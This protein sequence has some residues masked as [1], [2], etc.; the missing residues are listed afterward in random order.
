MITEVFAGIP[1]DD[2]ETATAWYRIFVNREPD[3]VPKDGEVV[4]RLA[5]NGWI[6]VVADEARAGSTI[7]TLLVDDLAEQVGSLAA[8]G[9]APASVETTPG[10]FRKAIFPDPA[11][12]TITLAQPG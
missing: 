6:Y 4:W 2:F 9:I 1:V 3:M 7:V 8:R 10:L 5:G 11:G 12:N